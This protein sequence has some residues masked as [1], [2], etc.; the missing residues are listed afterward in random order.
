MEREDTTRWGTNGEEASMEPNRKDTGSGGVRM[1]LLTGSVASSA[2][3]GRESGVVFD[4]TG[5]H[6][7]GLCDLA[8]ILTARL[9]SS[10]GRLVWVTALPDATWVVL[11]GLGLDHLFHVL[12]GPGDVLN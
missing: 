2:R 4:F 12:P 10:P 11:R 3:D 7:P 9:Q 8:L 6:R 5:L 1:E